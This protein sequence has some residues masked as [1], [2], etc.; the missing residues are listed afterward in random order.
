M[1]LDLGAVLDFIFKVYD[2]KGID[3]GNGI[4]RYKAEIDF[5]GRELARLYLQRQNLKDILR[6]MNAAKDEKDAEE[7]ML[8]HGENIVDCLGSEVDRIEKNLKTKHPEV[9]HVDLEVL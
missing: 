2:V 4:V 3:M 8:R 1:R 6:T 5:D 7:F 9:R